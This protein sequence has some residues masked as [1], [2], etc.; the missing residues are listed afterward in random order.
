MTALAYV[1]Q[2]TEVTIQTSDGVQL[3]AELFVPDE[4]RAAIVITHPNPLMGGDMYTPVPSALWR[5]LPE[6]G[7][8]GVRFNFRGVGR[9][10]GE[11]D[12]GVAEQLD[13]MAALEYLDFE[14]PGAPLLLGG[15]SFGADVSLAIDDDRVQGWFLAAA[16]LKVVAPA[17]MP[18]R[19]KSAPK[20]FA[21]PEADQFSPPAVVAEETADWT[22]STITVISGTDHFFGGA[23]DQLDRAFAEFVNATVPAT[24]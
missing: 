12:K 19:S 5:A 2:M 16:P 15:W 21:V 11:H 4:V 1:G 3:E 14:V 8:A 23:M 24:P 7:L 6:L 20:V 22:N 13:V 18:A 17:T 9:S 10:T